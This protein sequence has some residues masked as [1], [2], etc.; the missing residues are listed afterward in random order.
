MNDRRKLK[1]RH[2]LYYLLVFDHD[3]HALL[4]H[5][6]DITAAGV[7]LI[8]PQALETG[9]VYT[10]RMQ[11]PY[12][13]SGKHELVFSARSKWCRK[14]IN[15]DFY[16]TGFELLDVAGEDIQAV[17]WLIERSGFRD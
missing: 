8:S 4:G 6:V 14:D 10:L 15:P 11:L 9:R 12:E 16:D 17:E 7:M 5:L 3:T 13:I 1:R 2:I